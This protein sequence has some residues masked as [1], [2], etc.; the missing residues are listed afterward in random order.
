MSSSPNTHSFAPSIRVPNQ[1]LGAPLGT[2][3]TLL[4]YVEA[5]P[6]TINYWVKNGGEMLLDGS[7]YH[8][9][10]SRSG[11]KVLMSLKIRLFIITD[12]GTYNCVS[13]NSLGKAE[14][15]LR[16]YEIKLSS[17]DPAEDNQALSLGEL[18]ESSR[19]EKSRSELKKDSSCWR[20]SSEPTHL[21]IASSLLWWLST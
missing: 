1:L 12:V 2:D 6:N 15:T 10:E 5:F 21:L 18:A 7:K 8:V 19:G 13:T 14:G 16:L 3:V 17:L 9:K 4:C 20:V 11:Y